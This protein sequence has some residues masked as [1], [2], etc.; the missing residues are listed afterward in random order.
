MTVLDDP[1]ALRAADPGGML[2]FVTRLGDHCREGYAL[3]LTA[4]PLPAPDGITSIVVCGMGGSAIS[5]DVVAALAAPRLR[6][7]VLTVRAPELPEFCGPHTLVIS[8][9]YSGDTAETVS[10]FEEAVARGCRPI[11]VTAG[12]ELGRRAEELGIGRVIVPGGLMP[13]AAF[14][15]LSLGALGALEAMGIVPTYADDVE[16]SIG[17]LAGVVSD[18]GPDIPP[19]SNPAKELVRAIGDRVPVV[20]GAE[21]IG[22]VAASRWRCQFNE[23]AKVP[24]FAAAL[25]EL[26]H[27]EVVGWSAG[28]GVGF[29]VIGLRHPGEHA[30]VTVRFPPSLEIAREAGA[31]VHEVQSRGRSELARLLTLVQLGDLASTYLGIARGVDPSPIEAIVNLKRSLAQA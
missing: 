1:A 8:S 29:A 2:Q 23:N 20:W 27:N 4:Q 17:E 22:A 6:L 5:G 11:A 24:S 31:S 25:P 15:Y 26:D 9:S 18:A 12:G 30:D 21:G 7:P 10:L 16:E 28:R 19:V 14:G 13:R 3:G